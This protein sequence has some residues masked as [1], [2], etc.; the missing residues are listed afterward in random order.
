MSIKQILSIRL[1]PNITASVTECKRI[2]GRRKNQTQH[3]KLRMCI[4]FSLLLR[5]NL[6]VSL[7]RIYNTRAFGPCF[8]HQQTITKTTSSDNGLLGYSVDSSIQTSYVSQFMR[9]LGAIIRILILIF[10][11]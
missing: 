4:F 10:K 2:M 6:N 9:A 11:M 8:V 3:S 5:L 7:V 1:G